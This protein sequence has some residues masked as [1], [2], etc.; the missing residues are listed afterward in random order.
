MAVAPAAGARQVLGRMFPLMGPA[1]LDATRQAVQEL[2]GFDINQA[3]AV[4]AAS[5]LNCPLLVVHGKLDLTVPCWHGQSIYNAAP[6]PKRFHP[7]WWAG[8]ASILVG[9]EKWFADQIE[10]LAET[11][12]SDYATIGK[13]GRFANGSIIGRKR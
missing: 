10:R 8:H 12:S 4:Q 5:R 9:R 6:Q 11:A 2:A 13:S 1:K 3:S 7:V